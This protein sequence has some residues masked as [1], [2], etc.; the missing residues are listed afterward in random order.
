MP[1][2]LLYIEST[3]FTYTGDTTSSAKGNNLFI[4]FELSKIVG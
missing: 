4:Y 2:V 3:K 1:N